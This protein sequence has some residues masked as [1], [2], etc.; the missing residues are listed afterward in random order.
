MIA[1]KV[2]ENAHIENCLKTKQINGK[3]DATRNA[4]GEQRTLTL[5]HRITLII[6][7]VDILFGQTSTKYG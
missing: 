2:G 1:K 4:I 7:Q 5:L 6:G 3:P